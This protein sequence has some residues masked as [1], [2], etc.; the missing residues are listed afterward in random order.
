MS[1][2]A[3][4][5]MRLRGAD[6]AVEV[7]ASNLRFVLGESGGHASLSLRQGPDPRASVAFLHAAQTPGQ[8]SAYTA[9]SVTD[10]TSAPETRWN[11]PTLSIRTWADV[12]EARVDGAGM[13]CRTLTADA[14]TNLVS[15][16]ASDNAMLPPSAAA[17]SSAYIALSNMVVLSS[18]GMSGMFSNGVPGGSNILPL[19]DSYASSSVLSAPTANALRAAYVNLNNKL[20]MSAQSLSA[21]VPV[22]VRSAVVSVLQTAL[23]SNSATVSA[24]TTQTIPATSNGG[25]TTY[26]TN[27][28]NNTTIDVA[29]GSGTPFALSNDVFVT[30]TPDNQ[31]RALYQAFGAT[32]A[33]APGIGG[34]SA[35]RWFASDMG[36]DL[37]TMTAQ[38]DLW[39][40]GGVSAN[41]DVAV[42]GAC[43]VGGGLTVGAI[44]RV[45]ADAVGV[46]LPPGME[47][48][49]T[50]HVNGTL[51][52]TEQL[53][54]LSDKSVKTDIRPIPHAAEKVMRIRGCSYLRTDLGPDV[55]DSR[56]RQ[57]GVIAQDV[58][59]V[60]PEAVQVGADGRMSVAYGNLVA[61]A[62]EA[63]REISLE[64]TRMACCIRKLERMQQHPRGAAPRVCIAAFS[65]RAHRQR[66]VG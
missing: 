31:P 3:L 59:S 54:A 45:T 48:L 36:A 28:T 44:L 15:D 64:Q 43:S 66:G 12:E 11:T 62:L 56:R 33:V 25:P 1:T 18:A 22:M 9:L 40:N 34:V 32:V 26:I 63:I 61:L 38:G 58:H 46:N 27:V 37:M 20:A 13:S 57:V 47:P 29:Q 14:F 41:G 8:E 16:Y 39:L 49:A 7:S 5:Q 24:T 55:P 42:G 35:F 19:V 52:T 23:L 10:E 53:F 60:L 21:S 50:L 6:P 30:S 65:R 4:P 51:L 17:L 2:A